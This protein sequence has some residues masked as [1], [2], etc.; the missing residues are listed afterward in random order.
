[1]K[2]RKPWEE[3]YPLLDEDIKKAIKTFNFPTMTPVQAATVPLLIA[4]KD[5]AVQA[6]TGSG[7]T[8]AFLIPMLQLLKRRAKEQVWKV[9]EVG[10][11]IISP[12]RE[13]AVQT[14]TVLTQL[15]EHLPQ[16]KQ[17]LLVGGNSIEEDV[18]K[19][20]E[21]CNILVSTPGRLE[22]LLT[23]KLDF[24]LPASVKSL[25]LLILDEA[26]KLL[27]LGFTASLN[28]ILSY[29][30]RQRRTGLFSATQ[31]K[32]LQDLIRAG[33]RNPVVITV[34]EKASQSTP[35][36][37]DNYYIVT[38]NDGK[39]GTLVSFLE[40]NSIRKAL[41]FFPTCATVEYFSIVLKHILPQKLSPVL[42]IHGKMKEKRQ[43]IL[44]KFRNSSSGILL[45]TDVMARGIDI[46]EVDWVLQWDPPTSASAFVH[47]VGRT[48]RQGNQGSSLI[49]LLENEEPYVEFIKLNQNVY[50]KQLSDSATTEK[51]ADIREKLRSLQKID[52]ATMEKATRAFVSHVRAYS[53]HECSLILKV[54]DWPLGS[55]AA[56]YGLIRLPKMPELKNQDLSD[57]PQVED[58][59]FDSVPYKDKQK[60][61]QRQKK[62]ESYKSTGV[63]PGKQIKIRK[64][65]TE[66]WSKTKQMKEER[67]IKRQKRKN[68]KQMKIANNQPLKKKKRK[69]ISEEDMEELAKDIALIKKLKK[70][71][72]TDEQFDK[73]MGLC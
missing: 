36:T 25:E 20:R 30:P 22:D 54:K 53:K 12:T 8:L 65:P 61:E 45:C 1:M 73:E 4:M 68:T 50:L 35:V 51:I 46:P 21:G 44:D 40:E 70:R 62:L 57:F 32:E 64:K 52:R 48:A 7:K 3:I 47:R 26:D 43:K 66:P 6:V 10:S 56:M 63:W 37:L 41:L 24:N 29:L 58:F 60:E 18:K 31:T 16:F 23:R 49:F 59:D 15:L 38:R 67:K 71:K 69:G 13:L 72:I 19:L 5:V 9:K 2:S 27:D 55:V 14:N 34:T 17:C 33:L 39:L 11:I 42:A 28:T